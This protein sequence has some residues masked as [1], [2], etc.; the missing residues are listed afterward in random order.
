MAELIKLKGIDRSSDENSGQNTRDRSS[1]VDPPS[2]TLDPPSSILNSPS[3]ILN[4]RSSILDPRS[5][6]KQYWRSLEELAETEEFQELLHREFP[7]NAT[8]WT[9]PVG[10]RK[11]IK[12]MGAS[13]AL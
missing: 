6:G 2:S 12:L 3:S 9:D 8:E 13:F 1:I 11:F 7:E 5:S 4:L 10:R